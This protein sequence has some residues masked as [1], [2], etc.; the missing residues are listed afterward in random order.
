MCATFIFSMRFAPRP[1]FPLVCPFRSS[2]LIS[3]PKTLRAVKRDSSSR[4]IGK[5]FE[6]ATFPTRSDKTTTPPHDRAAIHYRAVNPREGKERP[7]GSLYGK[8]EEE[9]SMDDVSVPEVTLFYS[10]GA[11]SGLAQTP[12]AEAR[13]ISICKTSLWRRTKSE[14][15]GF[16]L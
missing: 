5:R 1:L 8:G 12:C 4:E 10:C 3:D 16:A 9:W 11:T 13:P 7:V 15:R 6:A 2:D 14:S